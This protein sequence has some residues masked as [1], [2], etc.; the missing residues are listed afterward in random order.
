MPVHSIICINGGGNVIYSTY[1]LD[2]TAS[3]YNTRLYFEQRLFKLT[4]PLWSKVETNPRTVMVGDIVV[5]FQMIGDMIVF[6][7]GV[8]DVD[9]SGCK[10]WHDV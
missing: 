7:N 9:E 3:D 1:F 5:V 10:E 4:S 6:A 8:D 2:A